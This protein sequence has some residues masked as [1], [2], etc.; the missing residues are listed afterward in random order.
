MVNS[1]RTLTH[2]RFFPL[3]RIFLTCVLTHQVHAL[4]NVHHCESPANC[5]FLS[6]FTKLRGS[7]GRFE[8]I[9][10]HRNTTRISPDSKRIAFGTIHK[11]NP[12]YESC[13]SSYPL[14]R[15]RFS[16]WARSNYRD[17]KGLRKRAS[18]LEIVNGVSIDLVTWQMMRIGVA[19]TSEPVLLGGREA[20]WPK[21]A[22]HDNG[23]RIRKFFSPL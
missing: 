20:K 21:K 3:A 12:K 15:F 5:T 17:R 4:T 8:M 14:N 13:L 22:F 10:V 23:R 1:I 19:R 18:P 16:W 2:F 6:P 9:R 7:K 11:D